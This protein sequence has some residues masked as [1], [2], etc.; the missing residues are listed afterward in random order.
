MDAAGKMLM[1]ILSHAADKSGLENYASR[2]KFLM[3]ICEHK[4]TPKWVPIQKV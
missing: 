1:A 4:A 3:M 2:A